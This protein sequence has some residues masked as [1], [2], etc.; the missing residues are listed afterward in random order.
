MPENVKTTIFQTSDGYRL[1]RELMI[2]T[3]GD[4]VF[5]DFHGIPVDSEGEPLEGEYLPD[6]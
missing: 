1:H 6:R 3:D 5:E 2:W 4:L